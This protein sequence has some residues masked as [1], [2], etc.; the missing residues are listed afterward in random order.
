ML[1]KALLDKALQLEQALN[2]WRQHWPS[3]T[4]RVK[5]AFDVGAAWV[6]QDLSLDPPLSCSK[7]IDLPRK[8]TPTK[9]RKI[10]GAMLDECIAA[11]RSLPG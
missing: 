7:G 10:V 2:A 3:A 1:D 6:V 8:L 11:A 4:I 5:S 9:A